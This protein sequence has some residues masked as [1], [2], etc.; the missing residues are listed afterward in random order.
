V[1]EFRAV[2]VEVWPL[3]ADE[4]S[5]WRLGGEDPWLPEHP[6]VVGSTPRGV[7]ELEVVSHRMGDR[8]ALLCG[9]SW[10]EGDGSTIQSYVA[11]ISTG[12]RPV[13]DQWPEA[14]A[15]T[16]AVA[17]EAGPAKAGPAVGVPEPRRLDVLMHGLRHLWIL[18]ERPEWADALS[19]ELPLVTPEEAAAALVPPWPERLREFEPVFD[20]MYK[21]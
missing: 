6:V 17:L 14:V 10:R 8:L 21:S 2:H 15:I 16:P 12:G 5:I 11:A 3:A 9:T 20:R 19:G 7:A 4:S 18:L 13:P 1:S